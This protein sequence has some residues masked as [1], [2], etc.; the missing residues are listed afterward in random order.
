[1]TNLIFHSSDFEFKG[2]TI[3]EFELKSGKLVRICLPNRDSEG[4][5]LVRKFRLELLKHFEDT[6]PN[7]KWTKEYSETG[8]RRFLKSISVGE[9][10]SKNLAVD[11]KKA[12]IIAEYLELE[13]HQKVKVLLIGKRKA[14]AIIC[15]FEKYDSLI[16][17]YYGVGYWE[18]DYLQ[19]LVDNE[20]KRGK[21]AIVLDRLEF[22]IKEEVYENIDRV[23]ITVGNSIYKTK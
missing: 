15:D 14:L 13:L 8:I 2:I 19:V 3:P 20:L 1:M 16:F 7:L 17:D 18:F 22:Q 6:I 21:S 9:Y 11:K 12:G 10:I 5:D 23:K 4:N